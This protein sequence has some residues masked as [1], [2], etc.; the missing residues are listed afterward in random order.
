MVFKLENTVKSHFN[1]LKT[2]LC[3][4]MHLFYINEMA[5]GQGEK[6]HILLF[7][8]L[9]STFHCELAIDGIKWEKRLQWSNTLGSASLYNGSITKFLWLFIW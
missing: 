1:R 4:N 3:C 6:I 5:S 8:Q 2:H 7:W 9:T